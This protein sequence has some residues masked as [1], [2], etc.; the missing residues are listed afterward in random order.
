MLQALRSIQMHQIQIWSSNIEFGYGWRRVYVCS[1]YVV[2][3]DASCALYR[4]LFLSKWCQT[5]T[6]SSV[7]AATDIATS[8]DRTFNFKRISNWNTSATPNHVFIKSLCKWAIWNH[9]LF[10]LL[11]ARLFHLICGFD[12]M[13]AI[14]CVHRAKIIYRHKAK[15]RVF[16]L[17][18]SM[19]NLTF[20]RSIAVKKNS[21]LLWTFKYPK[22]MKSTGTHRKKMLAHGS[23]IWEAYEV[24]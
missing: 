10:F 6:N 3:C 8:F 24:I 4:S 22:K 2:D 21:V 9:R 14:W 12:G 15:L 7:A 23:T 20:V 16:V 17:L 11:Y 18:F 1:A 5:L 13:A 19:L